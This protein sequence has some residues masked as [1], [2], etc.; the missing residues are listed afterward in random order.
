VFVPSKD[1]LLTAAKLQMVK[2][3]CFSWQENEPILK[4]SISNNICGQ[5]IALLDVFDEI[6]ITTYFNFQVFSWQLSMEWPTGHL[7]KFEFTIP[8]FNQ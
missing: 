1:K 2:L 7:S 6:H 5:Y 8:S 3:R 4:I